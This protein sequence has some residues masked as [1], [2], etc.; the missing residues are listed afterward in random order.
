MSND[1]RDHLNRTVTEAVNKA[2]GEPLHTSARVKEL[3]GKGLHDPKG[4]TLEEAKELC[5]SV[6]R[7]IERHAG[8]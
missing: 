6:M 5:G 7:H 1:D 2:Y 3:A 8:T 4:L